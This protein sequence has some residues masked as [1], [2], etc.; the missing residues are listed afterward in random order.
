MSEH[1]S[2]CPSDCPAATRSHPTQSP[3]LEAI[4]KFAE[5]HRLKTRV[6]SDDGTRIIPGKLGHIYEYSADALG[7]VVTP[8]P[9]R[10]RYWGCVRTTLL[11][12]GFTLVQDGDGEGAATFDPNHPIQA[13]AAIRAAGVNRKRQLSPDQRDQRT[14]FIRPAQESH[15]A[16]EESQDGP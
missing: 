4:Q 9:P 13:K 16:T 11:E 14:A 2:A 3:S 10:R 5:D 6:N 12:A 8:S 1:C 15:F 7:V